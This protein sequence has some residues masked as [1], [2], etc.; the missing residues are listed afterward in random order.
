MNI[1]PILISIFQKSP[2][3]NGSWIFRNKNFKPGYISVHSKFHINSNFC[4]YNDLM[5]IMKIHH[6]IIF[7]LSLYLKVIMYLCLKLTSTS[8]SPHIFC[9]LPLLLSGPFLRLKSFSV[10]LLRISLIKYI[11]KK[12]IQLSR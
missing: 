10:L 3:N 5:I 2:G 11:T 6:I 8:P 1:L 7:E 4:F 12:L 9:I